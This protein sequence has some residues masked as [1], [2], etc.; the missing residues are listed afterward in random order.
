MVVLWGRLGQSDPQKKS[1]AKRKPKGENLHE[2]R[3]KAETGA[4]G[5]GKKTRG[6]GRLGGKL[7]QK[8]NSSDIALT[9]KSFQGKVLTRQKRG[10]LPREEGVYFFWAT[11][12][13]SA[14]PKSLTGALG[15]AS[16]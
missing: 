11:R 10:W 8:G 13:R 9:K 7:Q 2:K 12:G 4:G 3:T 16:N 5:L 1:G 14:K 6:G 15:A